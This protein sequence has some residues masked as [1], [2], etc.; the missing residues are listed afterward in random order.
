MLCSPHGCVYSELLLTASWCCRWTLQLLTELFDRLILAYDSKKSI[1][2]RPQQMD[3]LYQLHSV[4]MFEVVRQVSVHCL[5]R[6][7]RVVPFS[8]W[9]GVTFSRTASVM[10]VRRH[11]AEASV[12]VRAGHVRRCL[13]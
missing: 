2:S 1:L 6:G 13:P 4:C 7:T 3:E 10:C 8:C 12:G 5:E 9:A 11:A